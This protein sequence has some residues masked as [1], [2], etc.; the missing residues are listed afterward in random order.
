MG[1]NGLESI[2]VPTVTNPPAVLSSTYTPTVS[3]LD[4]EHVNVSG[5]QSATR[6]GNYAINFSL[7]DPDS[8][9][10]ADGTEQT[11]KIVWMVPRLYHHH[12]LNTN[13]SYSASSSGGSY[14]N[15]YLAG[16]SGG[17]FTSPKYHV[18]VGSTYDGTGCYAGG[19][20]HTHTDPPTYGKHSWE[21]HP[22]GSSSLT[23]KHN[24]YHDWVYKG[25]TTSTGDNGGT[26]QTFYMYTCSHCGKTYESTNSN[27]P[28]SSYMDG[29]PSRDSTGY[30]EE[31]GESWTCR[32]CG[33]S[34]ITYGR[35]SADENVPSPE[36]A[37]DTCYSTSNPGY[38]PGSSYTYYDLNCGK[39]TSTV[40]GYTC[41]CG[42]TEGQQIN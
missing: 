18:H 22:T 12:A 34:V 29:C 19:T 27:A 31:P 36:P 9:E 14:G 20:K 11:K 1:L 13:G 16:S 8:T 41:S 32:Y 2:T 7:K 6:A 40:E 23:K 35:L 4:S 26:V 25:T 28:S 5:E 15:D 10:W 42:K 33:K 24:G 3:N 17:C 21:P 37:S 30:W 39:T 38:S